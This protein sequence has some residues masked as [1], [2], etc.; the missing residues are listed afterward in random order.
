MKGFFIVNLFFL[1]FSAVVGGC[2][3]LC[4]SIVRWFHATDDVK[5]G[6]ML[7]MG[8]ASLILAGFLMKQVHSMVERRL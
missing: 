5:K 7:I 4:L 6:L 8:I 2:L 3:F 1:L